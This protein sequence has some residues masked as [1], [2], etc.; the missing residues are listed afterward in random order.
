MDEYFAANYFRRVTSYNTF[1]MTPIICSPNMR[2]ELAK[3]DALKGQNTSAQGKRSAALGCG[4]KM[5]SSLFFQFGLAHRARPNWKKREVGCGVAFTQ[6]GGSACA[7]LRRALPLH[8]V[9]LSGRRAKRTE[10]EQI[11]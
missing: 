10:G 5:I 3:F 11:T 2:A 7:L 9:A 8:V 1:N 6:G 4:P